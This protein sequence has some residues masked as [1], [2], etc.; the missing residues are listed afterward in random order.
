MPLIL[1]K[2]TGLTV[3]LIFGAFR[4]RVY[5]PGRENLI[6][7]R[8]SGIFL[9]FGLLLSCVLF[10]VAWFCTVDGSHLPQA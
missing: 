10:S 5:L 4:M 1:G 9:C 2:L 3:F 8:C 7:G 6:T